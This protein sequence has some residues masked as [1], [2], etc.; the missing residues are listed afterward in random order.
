MLMLHSKHCSISEWAIRA[1][2]YRSIHTDRQ[3][4]NESLAEILLKVLM[5]FYYEHFA[6]GTVKI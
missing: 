3:I 4:E 6:V 1:S 2:Q 5:L